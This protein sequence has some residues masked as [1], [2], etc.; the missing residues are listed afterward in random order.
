MPISSFINTKRLSLYLSR[1]RSC[2]IFFKTMF[3][4]VYESYSHYYLLYVPKI[5]VH[6]EHIVEKI[7]MISQIT[8]FL[9]IFFPFHFFISITN[10]I[11]LHNFF[12]RNIKLHVFVPLRYKS[13]TFVWAHNNFDNNAK[14][15]DKWYNIELHSFYYTLKKKETNNVQKIVYYYAHTISILLYKFPR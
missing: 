10:S 8:L 2:K 4:R 11:Q 3:N 15:Q 7:Y 13:I 6:I 1:W 5:V 12:P 9:Y 14:S